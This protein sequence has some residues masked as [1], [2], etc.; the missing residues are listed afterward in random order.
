L[1]RNQVEGSTENGIE[2]GTIPGTAPTIIERNVT[3]ANGEDGIRV[4]T[5]RAVITRNRAN[6]NADFGIEAA[7]GVTDGGGNKARGNGNP[8]QCVNVRCR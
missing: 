8:A 6:F 4:T 5:T 1:S 7:P 2:V 3:S